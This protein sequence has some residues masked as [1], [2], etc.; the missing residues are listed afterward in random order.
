MSVM[1]YTLISKMDSNK[2]KKS[3]KQTH[4]HM[5]FNCTR[6]N[7][8]MIHGG[9]LCLGV[10]LN[11]KTGAQVEVNGRRYASRDYTS[12]VTTQFNILMLL[13]T[14]NKPWRIIHN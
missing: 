12:H 3:S 5:N 1:S 2:H 11:S 4:D 13:R 9:Y 10:S 14:L 7:E 6:C 8:H